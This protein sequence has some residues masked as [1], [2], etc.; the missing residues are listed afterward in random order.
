MIHIFALEHSDLPGS[1]QLQIKSGKAGNK[2][3]RCKDLMMLPSFAR[4][5]LI[6]GQRGLSNSIRW[7][8]KPEN[9]NFSKWVRGHELL[10][11][12]APVIRTKDFDLMDLLKK[13]VK[14]K[15]AGMLLLVGD[16]YIESIPGEVISFSNKNGF[17]I[18]AMPASIPLLDIFEEIGHAIAYD[19]K[20]STRCGELLMDVICGNSLDENIFKEKCLKYGYD[21]SGQQRM[22]IF[23]IRSASMSETYDTEDTLEIINACFEDTGIPVMTASFTGSYIGCLSEGTHTI[24]EIKAVCGAVQKKLTGSGSM[25]DGCVGDDVSETLV[26]TGEINACT[27]V[28]TESKDIDRLAEAGKKNAAVVYMGIGSTVQNPAQLHDS[29]LKASDCMKVLD[30]LNDAGGVYAYEDIGMYNIF[31]QCAGTPLV[32]DFVEHVLGVL[33]RYDKE[34]KTDLVPTL[35]SYLWNGCS[36]IHTAD[37]LF[38]HRNTIKYRVR[39]I[40]EITGKSLDSASVRFEFMNALLCMMLE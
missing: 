11:V 39:R 7:V 10:I 15:M 18:F 17:P 32:S 14:L 34:N 13:S 1:E 29:Y 5:K 30:K 38:T 25:S 8:Y 20:S 22:F 23:R 35:K 28:H 24:E 6:S 27:A 12:S 19:D 40:E 9:M 31:L 4:V 37:E 26:G 2:M 33:L 21:I 36:L 3:F 16:H